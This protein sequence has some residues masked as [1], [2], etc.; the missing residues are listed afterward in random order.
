MTDGTFPAFAQWRLHRYVRHMSIR[1]VR[2]RACIRPVVRP[3]FPHTI[4]E[5]QER[6]PDEAACLEYLVESRWPDG[7]RCPAP[8]AAS[9]PGCWGAGTYGGAL[10]ATTRPRHRRVMHGTGT[11][12]R[13]EAGS[14]RLRFAVLER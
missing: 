9:G 2:C 10:A 13:S 12:L 8:A 7:Y 6:F 1:F 4:V 5:F 3:D 11:S 14:G